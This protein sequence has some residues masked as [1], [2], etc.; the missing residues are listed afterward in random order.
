MNIRASEIKF[1]RGKNAA[2]DLGATYGTA[3]YPAS[4]RLWRLA[5]SKAWLGSRWIWLAS[6]HRAAPFIQQRRVNLRMGGSGYKKQRQVRDTGNSNVVFFLTW[7]IWGC[8]SSNK[9]TRSQFDQTSL[10]LPTRDYFLQPSNAIYLKA[11]KDYLIK[12]AM[13]LGAPFSNAMMHAEELIDFETQLATVLG[14]I[15][16]YPFFAF[17]LYRNSDNSHLWRRSTRLN[18]RSF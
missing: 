17:H 12:I 5:D 16:C 8:I 9:C 14:Y 4:R 18:A 3:T 1:W 6:S 7:D 10:G 11:Y 2:R 13:L 15:I